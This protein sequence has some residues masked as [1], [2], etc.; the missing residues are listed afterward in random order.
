MCNFNLFDIFK[1]SVANP[2]PFTFRST[3]SESSMSSSDNNDSDSNYSNTRKRKRPLTSKRNNKSSTFKKTQ[4]PTNKSKS[5]KKKKKLPTPA[6]K[7]MVKPHYT[8]HWT[9]DI[10]KYGMPLYFSTNHHEPKHKALK[11]VK[12]KQTNQHNHSRDIL[13]QEWLKQLERAV[14]WDKNLPFPQLHV[15]TTPKVAMVWLIIVPQ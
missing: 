13:V 3:S 2:T 4:Q 5:K 12:E 1:T 15:K 6:G 7:Q 9:A 14:N 11:L 8:S 10:L